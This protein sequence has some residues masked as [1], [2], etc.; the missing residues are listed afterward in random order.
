VISVSD[1]EHRVSL[2]AF[3][4]TVAQPSTGSATVY[5]T[6]PTQK[7]DGSA[8]GNLAGFRVLYGRNSS[9]LDRVATIAN[10][11]ATSYTVNGLTSGTWY[12]AVKAYD[13]AN[14]ESELSNV[15]SKTI[16]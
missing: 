1:G 15:R 2:P 10:A 4:I 11:N 7:T 8:L 6:P 5:W 9:N 14:V 13:T 16:P 3:T 12:F